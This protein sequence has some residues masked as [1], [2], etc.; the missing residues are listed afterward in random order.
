V[1]KKGTHSWYT[2][3]RGL[4]IM[5]HVSTCLPFASWDQ[6]KLQIS[7][8]IGNDITNIIFIEGTQPYNPDALI[9]AVTHVFGVVQP[10]VGADSTR[11]L[12]LFIDLS[13]LS[14][15][16]WR[17]C[18]YRVGVASKAFVPR[19]NPDLPAELSSSN[20]KD[21]FLT[22]STCHLPSTCLPL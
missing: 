12:L 18:S 10:I 6:H 16:E 4:E 1:N 21:L 7:R 8:V 9:S 22:K 15:I 2:R 17:F 19:F 14:H 5:F 13:C 11:C 3:W 20:L